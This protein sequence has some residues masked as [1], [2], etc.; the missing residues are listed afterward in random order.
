MVLYDWPVHREVLLDVLILV[1]LSRP[2]ADERDCVI[3]SDNQVD[4]M[5]N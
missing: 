1:L 2:D 4:I 3:N 5:L